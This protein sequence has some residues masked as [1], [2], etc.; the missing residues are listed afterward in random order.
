MFLHKKLL[1][2]NLPPDSDDVSDEHFI[3]VLLGGDY[4]TVG[5]K[6]KIMTTIFKTL[7]PRFSYTYVTMIVMVNEFF[8][9]S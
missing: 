1:L 8:S 2:E 6:S 7:K 3:S 5:R 9:F 4:L